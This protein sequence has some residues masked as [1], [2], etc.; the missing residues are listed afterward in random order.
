MRIKKYNLTSYPH[1]IKWKCPVSMMTETS[2]KAND[3]PIEFEYLQKFLELTG[4][5]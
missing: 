2:Y 5:M 3:I 4:K 1:L